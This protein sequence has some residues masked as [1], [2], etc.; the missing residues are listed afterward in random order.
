MKNSKSIITK[1]LI[2]ILLIISSFA[3]A[4]SA[5]GLNVV[6]SSQNPDPVSPGNFVFVNV[7]LSNLGTNDI[8]DA[9]IRM[10][11][12]NNFR[13]ASGS[14]VTKRV[15][16]IPAY[17]GTSTD[18]SGFII[19]KFKV[20][21]DS[22]TPL[23]LNTLKFQV[24]ADRTYEYEFDILVEDSNPTIQVNKFDLEKVEAGSSSK[25]T[26]EIENT[27]SITLKNVII[28]LGLDDIEDKVINVESG[29]NQK[30]LR[31][32]KPGE[33]VSIEYNLIVNPDAESKP[34]QVP[35]E[36]IYEDSLENSFSTEVLV[37]INVYSKPI[38]DINLD[39]QT[40]YTKGK[41]QITLAVANP[42]TS[43]V[44][45]VRIELLESDD[46]EIIE[47]SYQYVGDLNPDDFQTIQ[48]DIFITYD[49]NR[50]IAH[51]IV[52][53]LTYKTVF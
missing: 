47:G 25:L 21:V 40:V 44:K 18:S 15:G 4:Y 32:I 7:K 50:W 36:I 1:I 13:I 51:K 34:Y 23:G 28:T 29:S 53:S 42:G 27:N 16:S 33:K 38:L 35:V 22:S 14:D 17:S 10:I 2:G 9:T 19:A 12:N 20:L 46:Y 48:T 5:P 24:D 8:K 49:N 3:V 37:S 31:I 39:S 6:L 45:G 26:L 11:E 43:T 30:T 41:G 52:I